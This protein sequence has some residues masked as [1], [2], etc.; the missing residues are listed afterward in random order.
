MFIY[1]NGFWNGFHSKEDPVNEGFFTKLISMVFNQSVSSTD[2][3]YKA[4]I[5]IESIF[6]DIPVIQSKSWNYSILFS[7]ESRISL[8]ANLYST[9]LWMNNDYPKFIA[10]P[11]FIP[12][13][14][15]NN[16]ENILRHSKNINRVPSKM[17]C[18]V[19]SNSGAHV[20]N[21]FINTLSLRGIPVINGGC[22]ENTLGYVIPGPYN[23]KSLIDFISEYK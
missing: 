10:L 13:L 20:R 11:L 16:L 18:V 15:C 12:Y 1:Y 9:V 19:N 23:S 14:E 21:S 22:Y 2:D 17:V 5:L 8:N 4:D 3:I 7:G 6:T